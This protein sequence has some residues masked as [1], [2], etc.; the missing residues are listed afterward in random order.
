[1]RQDM[2]KGKQIVINLNISTMKLEEFYNIKEISKKEMGET[3]GGIIPLVVGVIA[4]IGTL[5]GAVLGGA[6]YKGYHDAKQE[7]KN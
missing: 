4:A 7:C 6:Y 1:M 3:S 2:I 5:Y